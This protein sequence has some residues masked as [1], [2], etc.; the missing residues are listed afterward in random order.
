M[1]SNLQTTDAPRIPLVGHIEITRKC[2]FRCPIC[3][4]DVQDRQEMST[5]EILNV[6]DDI[7]HEGCLYLNISGGEPFVR[8]DFAEIYTHIVNNGIHPSIESNGSIV[9][10]S[11][12]DMLKKYPPMV[13]NISIYGLDADSFKATTGSKIKYSKV[14]DNLKLLWKNGISFILRTPASLNN[15]KV[16]GNLHDFAKELGVEFKCDPKVW[17]NQAGKR[18]DRMRVKSEQVLPLIDTHP[19]YP[20]LY[21]AL[22]RLE[23]DPYIV[24]TCRWGIYEFY[25]N[26]YG[27]L[28]YCNTFWT[29][30]YDLKK[31][32]FKDAWDN[33]YPKFRR[34]EQNYCAG[35]H[36]LPTNG[37][38]P[39]GYLY[40]HSEMDESKSLEQRVIKAIDNRIAMGEAL[41]H[42]L[43]EMQISNEV[44]DEIYNH[45]GS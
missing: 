8:K 22:K 13:F 3:Y 4:N 23:A 24:S 33:W 6:I 34:Q 27:E 44:Y 32:S 2:N 45:R 31:G 41:P 11:I 7:T 36:V 38:C 14:V 40:F 12:I 30:K 39:A 1:I 35:K 5:S 15:Y 42:V 37:H 29:T 19:I 26:P 18:Y 21:K 20:R 17:S 10:P 25:I 43:T 9:T 16:L 28:H